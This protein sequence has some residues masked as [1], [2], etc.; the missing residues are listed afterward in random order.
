MN[1]KN[2][3]FL[4]IGLVFFAVLIVLSISLIASFAS[5]AIGGFPKL[6][7]GLFRYYYDI[8]KPKKDKNELMRLHQATKVFR[9]GSYTYA[10]TVEDRKIIEKDSAKCTACHGNMIELDKNKKPKYYIHWKMLSIPMLKL[11]CT[12]CHKQVDI[13]KRGPGQMHLVKVDRSFCP[14]CHNE[15]I[16]SSGEVQK[17][18]QHFFSQNREKAAENAPQ[19]PS[20]IQQHI[21]TDN[22]SGKTWVK[23]HS[24]VAKSVGVDQCKRCHIPNSELDFCKDCH[25]EH[26]HNSQWINGQHGKKARVDFSY[27]LDC[28][29]EGNKC[30]SCHKIKVPHDT[31]TKD[32]T[33]NWDK[34][35]YKQ[36][37][38]TLCLKCH[39]DSAPQPNATEAKDP[40][41]CQKC[42]HRIFGNQNILGVDK[43]NMRWKKIHFNIVKESGAQQCFQCHNVIYCS[44]CHIQGVKPPRNSGLIKFDKNVWNHEYDTWL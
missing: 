13:R 3:N 19:L 33:K 40:D 43:A 37:D 6:R 20:V 38:M 5:G 15:Q 23:K 7:T 41:F 11:Q 42:H 24:V 4:V 16:I 28:H 9:N 36:K 31:K 25:E 44:R 29:I 2:K 30:F 34:I 26:P 10:Y 17:D 1:K 39:K 35:H 32:D 18:W 21:I 12:E 8:T 22:Q 27:C 14:K